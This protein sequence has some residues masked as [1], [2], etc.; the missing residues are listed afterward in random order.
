MGRSVP[1]AEDGVKEKAL[2]DFKTLLLRLPTRGFDLHLSRRRNQAGAERGGVLD[3]LLQPPGDAA[4]RGEPI[5]EPIDVAS[6]ELSSH[7]AA[8]VVNEVGLAGLY[9]I[10]PGPW[11]EQAEESV[12]LASKGADA[13]DVLRRY[14]V[15][16]GPLVDPLA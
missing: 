6:E 14:P 9:R 5:V 11:A 3:E 12:A 15:Q 2:I 4:L 1:M 13:P 10:A 16:I 7:A 8:G